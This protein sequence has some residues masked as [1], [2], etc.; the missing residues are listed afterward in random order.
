MAEMN[1]EEKMINGGEGEEPE[2]M[3]GGE[4]EIMN[5]GEEEIMNGGKSKKS[6][7]KNG[8]V[9]AMGSR[10][11]VY[12]GFAKHTSG[13]L[14]KKDLMMNKRGRIVSKKKHFSEKKSKKLRGFK[15]FTKSNNPH[16]SGWKPNTSK[17]RKS[18]K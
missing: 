10:S 18:K 12:N 4:E 9:R 3:N 5:G 17:T 6:S 8:K 1:E 15:P 14:Y 2:I 7:S 11:S 13:G 16:K